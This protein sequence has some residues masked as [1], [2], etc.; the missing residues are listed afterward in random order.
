MRRTRAMSENATPRLVEGSLV[1]P[2]GA[3]FAIVAS[4]FNHFIVDRLVDGALD[5]H[6][7]P[8]RRRRRT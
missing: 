7:A 3:R 8:R 2:P 1:V 6:R 4:R 5:A